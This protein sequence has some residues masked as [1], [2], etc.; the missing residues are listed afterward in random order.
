MKKP[1]KFRSSHRTLKM[2]ETAIL[3]ALTIILT[4]FSLK[5]GPLEM[6]LAPIPVMVGAALLG[7]AVGTALGACFGVTSFLMC[8][9]LSPFGALLLS[10]NWFL[11]FLVCVPTRTLMGFLCGM[12]YRWL[13]PAAASM[14]KRTVAGTV[15]ALSA[16]VLNTAFFLGTL[17]LFFYHGATLQGMMAGNGIAG[18]WG[19]LIFLAGINALVEAIVCTVCGAAV[20]IAMKE[21]VEKQFS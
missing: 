13:S 17:L 18:V 15:A 2:T 10:E 1:T 6:T 4:L 11:A 12:I 20:T 5:I 14:Q 8:F 19:L 7:P 3:T 9:G 16:P 21:Y